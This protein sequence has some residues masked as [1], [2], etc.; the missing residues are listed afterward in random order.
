VPELTRATIKAG[1]TQRHKTGVIAFLEFTN[2]FCSDAPWALRYMRGWS[3][4]KVVEWCRGKGWTF[5]PMEE[6]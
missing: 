4:A 6:S 3:R 1:P 5:E 2:D